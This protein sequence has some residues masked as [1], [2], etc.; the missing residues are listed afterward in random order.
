MRSTREIL[1]N[2]I[3]DFSNFANKPSRKL[4]YV[5][6]VILDE[7]HE[8]IKDSN[9]KSAL[10]GAIS[11]RTTEDVT[12][13]GNLPIAFPLEK[14]LKSVPVRNEKVEIYEFAPKFYGYRRIGI[15]T[16]P[17]T[18]VIGNEIENIFTPKTN[19]NNKPSQYNKVQKTKI[20]RTNNDKS[21]TEGFGEY[22]EPQEGIHKLKL[23]EGDTLLESRFGQSIRFSAYNNSERT[24]SPTTIIRNGE[25][26]TNRQ[27]DENLPVEED[28]N[29]DGSVIVMSSGDYQLN[30]T[31][32]TIL[33]ESF[34]EIP[35]KFIGDN[36][37]INS[38][39]VI[40]SAKNEEMFF[41]SKK[42]FAFASEGDLSFDVKSMEFFINDNFT[43]SA[44]E[45][46]I[47]L[48]SGNNGKINLGTNTN[49]LEPMVKGNT[50]VEILSDLIEIV[51]QAQFA[52]PAGLSAPGPTNVARLQTLAGKLNNCLSQK[53]STV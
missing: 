27:V 11:F 23:Y 52:T 4:G 33:P 1:S 36:I 50:L 10:I 42:G 8:R 28:I 14:T 32:P 19:Q 20:T 41:Y 46:K 31:P 51:G 39:R 17:T 12:I 16:N 29:Q 53:N 24:F 40:L 43:I 22:Y 25:S 37:L 38:G 35:Q 2:G 18:N 49:E 3:S 47:T 34:P 6:E 48:D 21:S 5:Y 30:F 13:D 45:R 15:E 7:T 26:P 9:I 44:K